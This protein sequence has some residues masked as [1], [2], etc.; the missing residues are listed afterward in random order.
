MATGTPCLKPYS[1]FKDRLTIQAEAGILRNG[2]VPRSSERRGGQPTEQ[3][4]PAP[5]KNTVLPST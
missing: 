4:M 3:C 1:K 2:K 5:L